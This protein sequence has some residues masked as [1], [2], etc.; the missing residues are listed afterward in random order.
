MD[1]LSLSR[2]RSFPLIDI[3]AVSPFV[4][5]KGYLYLKSISLAED[6]LSISQ[7]FWEEGTF[8]PVGIWI[9]DR[10]KKK[11]IVMHLLL[12]ALLSYWFEAAA[13]PVVWFPNKRKVL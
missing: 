2:E 13:C 11:I 9:F 4:H 3:H 8:T 10:K 7:G 5:F 6:R 1:T 12:M